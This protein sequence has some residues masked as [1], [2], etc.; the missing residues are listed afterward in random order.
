[1]VKKSPP[2]PIPTIRPITVTP[3]LGNAAGKKEVK[4]ALR[5]MILRALNVARK[6]TITYMEEIVPESIYRVPDYPDSYKSEA[7]LEGAVAILNTSYRK[8][9]VGA[10]LKPVYSLELGFPA[11]YA[12][13][14]DKMKG[15][16]WS[17]PGSQ[18]DFYCKTKAFLIRAFRAALK[19]ELQ[20]HKA[21][22]LALKQRIEVTTRG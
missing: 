13:H 6:L 3:K 14:V 8:M 11:S 17:K 12:K 22:T 20:K 1:M 9:K 7:L 21:R 18:G 10:G 16:N 19:R 15:V 5:Q 4:A 2:A